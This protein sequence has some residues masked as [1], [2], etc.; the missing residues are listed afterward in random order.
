VILPPPNGG[1][2]LEPPFLRL[3]PHVRAFVADRAGFQWSRGAT[4]A[5]LKLVAKLKAARDRKRAVRRR[6]S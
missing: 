2:F 1:A 4:I 5:E 6:L 3:L